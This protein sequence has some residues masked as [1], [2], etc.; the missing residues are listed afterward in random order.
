MKNTCISVFQKD[1]LLS[2]I[3][4]TIDHTKSGCLL[5]SLQCLSQN[6]SLS[7]STHSNIQ[8]TTILENTKPLTTGKS[9][10]KIVNQN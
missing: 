8:M 10:K 3:S 5:Y 2:S 7:V 4:T 6:K 9:I 1:S